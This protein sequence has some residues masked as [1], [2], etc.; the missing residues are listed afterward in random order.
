S[1]ARSSRRPAGLHGNRPSPATPRSPRRVVPGSTRRPLVARAKGRIGDG[2]CERAGVP[3]GHPSV[4]SRSWR[5]TMPTFFS[6]A[7]HA[8]EA[9]EHLRQLAGPDVVYSDNAAIIHDLQE[10]VTSMAQ[11]VD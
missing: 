1:R 2:R 5:L 6:P 4:R 11:G 8:A 7:D 3:A 9:A 10:A